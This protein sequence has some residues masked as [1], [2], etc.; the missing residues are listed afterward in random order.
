MVLLRQKAA[1]SGNAM[2]EFILVAP[3]LLA[4]AIN[5][6]DLGSA[7]WHHSSLTQ[8][9]REIARDASGEP[10]LE[11]NAV[12]ST[13]AESD[14]VGL[15]SCGLEYI[16]GVWINPIAWTPGNLCSVSAAGPVT[17]RLLQHNYNVLRLWEREEMLSLVDLKRG[18]EF[19]APPPA[20]AGLPRN[21]TVTIRVSYAGLFQGQLSGFVTY[22][23]PFGDF[24]IATAHT[25]G[26][27]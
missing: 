14:L 11:E 25:I 7:L 8:V 10:G 27:L 13:L 2:L 9:V 15:P 1:Q 4:C 12:V 23:F 16:N 3:I 17:Y 22:F 26:Y 24:P 19:Y 21:I 6:Y 20:A 18:I 5:V